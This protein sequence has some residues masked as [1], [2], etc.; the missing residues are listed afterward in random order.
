[1]CTVCLKIIYVIYVIYIYKIII[2]IFLMKEYCSLLSVYENESNYPGLKSETWNFALDFSVYFCIHLFL[3][4]LRML[5]ENLSDNVL[6]LETSTF[7]LAKYKIATK[8]LGKP[9]ISYSLTHI[10]AQFIFFARFLID[11][12]FLVSLDRNDLYL[13]FTSAVVCIY[14]KYTDKHVDDNT[15]YLW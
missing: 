10:N 15:T 2:H 9:H 1:M 12:F 8:M 13:T 3:H 5:N 11:N 7:K 6:Y 4:N 14:Y